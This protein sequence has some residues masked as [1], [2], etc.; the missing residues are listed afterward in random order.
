MLLGARVVLPSSAI[1]VGEPQLANSGARRCRQALW[2]VS[3]A[4][5]HLVVVILSSGDGRST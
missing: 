3:Y 2:V 1:R 5:L 4:R